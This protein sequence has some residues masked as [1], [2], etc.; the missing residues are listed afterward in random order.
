MQCPEDN[1]VAQY[2][3]KENFLHILSQAPYF[4]APYKSFPLTNPLVE[5]QKCPCAIW[6]LAFE[7]QHSE[8]TETMQVLI[9]ETKLNSSG[10]S[11]P[12]RLN[13]QVTALPLATCLALGHHSHVHYSLGKRSKW[14]W[15]SNPPILLLLRYCLAKD[16]AKKKAEMSKSL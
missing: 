11:L 15:N 5:P 3:A 8:I 12:Q 1:S 16:M 2:V 4:T 13:V 10:F 7:A 9:S 14:S 6:H